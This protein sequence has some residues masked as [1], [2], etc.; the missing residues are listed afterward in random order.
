ML[1]FSVNCH[2]R[3]NPPPKSPLT[4]SRNPRLSNHFPIPKNAHFRNPRKTNTLAHSS[5]NHGGVWG[6]FPKRETSENYFE[7]AGEEIGSF[8]PSKSTKT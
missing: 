1:F 6:F 8:A 5:Q 3:S 2:P 4:H 7:G